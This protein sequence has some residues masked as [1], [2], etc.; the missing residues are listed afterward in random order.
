MNPPPPVW[1]ASGCTTASAKPT[2]TAAS[3]AFPPR[4]MMSRPTSL[5]IGLPETTMAR[6]PS[7]TR[8]L[9]ARD[10]PGSMPGGGLWAASGV[11]SSEAARTAARRRS[12]SRVMVGVIYPHPWP[13][14]AAGRPPRD[15]SV[16]P[17][18]HG[19][20][21]S[22]HGQDRRGHAARDREP[23]RRRGRDRPRG[24]G[25]GAGRDRPRDRAHRG[26]LPRRRSPALKEAD[27]KGPRLN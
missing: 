23:H 26:L 19:A 27:R 6:A 16:P 10:Q 8:A 2:A 7:V 3:T 20:P 24:G 18:P 22:P 11:A 14:T 15:R 21:Q 13:S 1:P 12:W 25:T 4:R 5:A 9:P 17:P